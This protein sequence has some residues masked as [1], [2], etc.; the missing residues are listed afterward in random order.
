VPNLRGQ[1]PRVTHV[2]VRAWDRQGVDLDFEV[3]GLTAG[4]FQHE[5]DHLDGTLFVD[6]VTDSRTLCTWADYERFHRDEFV[7]KAKALVARFGS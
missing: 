3:K 4:T 6:R 2:R 7:A 1:V 5:L